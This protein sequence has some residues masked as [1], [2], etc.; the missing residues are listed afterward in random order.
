MP[1]QDGYDLIHK[2][3][4][5]DHHQKKQCILIALTA[6][7][8]IENLEKALSAGFGFHLAKPVDIIKLA[9]L[10]KEKFLLMQNVSHSVEK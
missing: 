6:Y 7:A 3:R 10:I 9:L 5:I 8:G 4:Q 2:I 1:E